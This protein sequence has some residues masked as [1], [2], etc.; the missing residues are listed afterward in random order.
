M[1]YKVHFRHE[2]TQNLPTT[3]GKT[4]ILLISVGHAYHEG[5]KLL[6][7]IDLI[8]QSEF[9]SCH[10][11]L[12]DSLQR[13]NYYTHLPQGN[14]YQLALTNGLQWIRKNNDFLCRLTVPYQVVRWDEHLLEVNYWQLR[15]R[16]LKIYYK[17]KVFQHAINETIQKFTDRIEKRTPS[18]QK[19]NIYTNS[20]AYLMEECPIVM[21]LW[22]SQGYDFII[23]PQPMTTAMR[24]TYRTFVENQYKDKVIWLSLRF[25]KKHSINSQI[26]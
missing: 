17:N 1:V 2:H 23:Y 7:T 6:A 18:T 13:Y 19:N 15:K 3:V 26:Y 21:P 9:K 20:L 11:M 24:Y 14:A 22:A 4:A 10:I 12:A 5:E 25:K 16:L 8:N